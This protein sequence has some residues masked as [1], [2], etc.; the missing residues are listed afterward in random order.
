MVVRS[1]VGKWKTQKMFYDAARWCYEVMYANRMNN[2]LNND[3]V[4]SWYMFSSFRLFLWYFFIIQLTIQRLTYH[5]RTFFIITRLSCC[6][7]TNTFVSTMFGTDFFIPSS[8][9]WSSSTRLRTPWP[10]SPIRP[11]TMHWKYESK[12]LHLTVNYIQKHTYHIGLV[13]STWTCSQST[14]FF[15]PIS[16]NTFI[17]T[18]FGS[19]CYSPSSFSWSNATRFVTF[20]KFAPIR[21]ST[22]H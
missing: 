1:E 10:F 7:T 21:P 14:R 3:E 22:I 20:G 11:S 15:V 4:R 2:N 17:A 6:V 9:L 8:F 5:T 16:S 19:C 18:I 12:F 13:Y